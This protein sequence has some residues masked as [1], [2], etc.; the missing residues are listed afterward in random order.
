[1]NTLYINIIII[2]LTYVYGVTL[3]ALGN[4]APDV[5]SSLSAGGS[6]TTSVGFYL[7]ASSV[8]GSG[9]FV[10]TIISSAIT[11]MTNKPIKVTPYFF[12][13]DVLFYMF[14]CLTVG[15]AIVIRKKIDIAFSCCFLSIYVM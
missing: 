7:A 5:F 10:S 9:M 15:Y 1:M 12:I 11:L 2:N 13:R 3:L 8:L 6:D 4:G 14:M